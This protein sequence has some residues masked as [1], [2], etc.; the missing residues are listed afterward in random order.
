MKDHY[1][2]IK[3][4]LC[5]VMILLHLQV[6]N[7]QTS[8]L[9]AIVLP[10][11]GG[12]SLIV[13]SGQTYS[14]V[15]GVSIT[16]KPGVHFKSGSNIILRIDNSISGPAA[17]NN[18]NENT[19]MNWTLSRSYDAGGAVIGESKSFFDD[20]GKLLQTQ[21]KNMEASHVLATQ[22]LY[23][24]GGKQVGTTLSAPINNSAFAYKADFVRGPG[25]TAFGYR[26]YSLYINQNTISDKRFQPDPV[27]TV[28]AG[29][30]GSLGQYYSSKNPWER[31]Q[32]YTNMPYS[33]SAGA[34]N[35]TNIYSINGGVGQNFRL[36]SSHETK[37]F[38][39]PVSRELDFY[40]LVRRTYL[41]AEELGDTA[42]MSNAQKMMTV[43][44]D[45]DGRSAVSI[46]IDGRT[47]MSGREGSDLSLKGALTLNSGNSGYFAVLKSQTI[48]FPS[49]KLKD[50]FRNE[51]ETIDPGTRQVLPG[52]YQ[53][54]GGTSPILY[55]FGLSDV[56][57]NLYDHLGR[58]KATI[59]P[60]GVKKLWTSG[61]SSF[62]TLASIPFVK[63][64]K[65]DGRGRLIESTDPDAGKSARKYSSDGKLRYSQNAVQ[66][67][68]NKFSY[69]NYDR[70]GRSVES[71]ELLP[72]GTVKFETLTLAMLDATEDDRS[73]YPAGTKSDV[74]TISYDTAS[75]VPSLPN[76]VQDSYFLSG[77][78]IST[79]ARYSGAP[80][81]ATL[82]T[83]TWYNYDGDGKVIWVV[84]YVAG[85]GYKTMDYSYDEL[86]NVVKSIYQK[87]TAGETMVHYF[88]YDKNK[89]LIATYTNTTDIATSKVLHAK[90]SY[91]L[92][93]PLKRVELGDKLQ[94]IDYVY[95]IDGKLKSINNANASKDP[96][97]DGG[98]GFAADVFGMNLEYYLG[99]Y[100][101][102]QAGIPSIQSGGNAASYSGLIN[103]ISWFSKKP[104][105][106]DIAPV[107]N[108][109]SYDAIGQ[110]TESRWGTPNFTGS[111][112]VSG[113][114][115]NR[116]RGLSYDGHGNI[117][118]LV[119][120]NGLSGE[121]G[122]Y[123]YNYQVNTN[124]LSSVTGY[125]TYAYDAVGQLASQIKGNAGMY[126]DYD[127]SGK[128]TKIYSDAAKQA[129][130]LS[131]VYDE[132]GNRVMKK[133]HRTGAVTWYSLDGNGSL[134]AIFEQQGAGAIQL[135]EQ[136]VYGS[137]RLGT[138]YRLGSNYQYTITDHVGNTR[139]VINR[140]KTASGGADIVYYAD[141]YPFGMELRSGGVENRYGYQGLYAEKD[142]E[143]GWNNFELRNYDAAIGRWLTTDPK[144]QYHSPYIGMGNNPV[145]RVDKD[146]GLDDD[147]LY[148]QKGEEIDRIPN[149]AQ[150]RH[151]MQHNDGNYSYKR[152]R[153]IQVNSKVTV[154]GDEREIGRAHEIAGF[155]GKL[156]NF[157][158]KLDGILNAAFKNVKGNAL[159]MALESRGG[160]HL[161]FMKEFKPGVLYNINGIYYN[162]HEALNYVWGA[163]L[164]K[165]GLPLPAPSIAKELFHMGFH[166]RFEGNEPEHNRAINRGYYNYP[167]RPSQIYTIPTYYNEKKWLNR[168]IG[169]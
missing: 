126:L 116:E 147:I 67:L 12:S 95:S 80:S 169:R 124:K 43:S 143:T 49:G 58:L 98:N 155:D 65:Y 136:P 152:E 74:M 75:V 3:A 64:F 19:N 61:V 16:L 132:D 97:M 94:G 24:V 122:N 38:N 115:I 150:D 18:P 77:G 20:N 50:Y 111:S 10:A 6:A 148:N 156:E 164:K 83:K 55:Q 56:S 36:G 46:S 140:N 100:N 72:S 62:S 101:N 41:S 40:N 168:S 53:F 110:L 159:S 133:D 89:R 93:G 161:D 29:L 63:T 96:G 86:G 99:D 130:I 23:D 1:S 163:S 113:G 118:T 167:G 44:F 27:D 131:F 85:L 32:D 17:P 106:T 14:A 165:A 39:V 34:K 157:T 104:N 103:G 151:F 25:N 149:D 139:V 91:Y 123:T 141:Y 134:A 102:K 52:L 21:T 112:F 33:T 57:F 7:A 11:N 166:L 31:L 121:I 153:Y 160:G 30:M 47:V 108:S 5:A 88:E 145:G 2:H 73:K 60:E 87:G 92:H 158:A 146:G 45:A 109:Y 66:K 138:F 114:E 22:P 79:K 81:P 48:S 4:F 71:G 120:T 70:Y 69:T 68:A 9:N 35:G 54:S 82:L 78:A 144:G 13:E 59:P 129:I 8:S 135:K 76:Y 154:I 26:N 127:V 37:Q 28:T 128:V 107:M 84:K 117:K 125:A 42:L 162:N 142:K 105:S 90:Y 119:R 15:S 51:T 137:D